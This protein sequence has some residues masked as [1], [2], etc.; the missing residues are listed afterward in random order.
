MKE[1]LQ[2]DTKEITIRNLDKYITYKKLQT[3]IT[4]EHRCKSPQ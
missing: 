2:L 3:N 1:M 4:H